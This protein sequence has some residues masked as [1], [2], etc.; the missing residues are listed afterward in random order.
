[1]EQVSWTGKVT[2]YWTEFIE[3]GYYNESDKETMVNVLA[4][5]RLADYYYGI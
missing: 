3:K 4:I 5:P 2:K 1:M